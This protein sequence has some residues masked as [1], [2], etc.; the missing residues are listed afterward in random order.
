[1][2]KGTENTAYQVDL[3]MLKSIVVGWSVK[4]LA[5][6]IKILVRELVSRKK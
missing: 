3:T 6:V 2:S 4:D 1:M 5:A